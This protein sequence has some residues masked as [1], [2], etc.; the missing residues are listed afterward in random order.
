MKTKLH[1]TMQ[2]SFIKSFVLAAVTALTVLLSPT[3]VAQIVSSG[4]TGTVRGADGK[5]LAGATVTAVHTPTNATFST[6]ANDAGRFSFRSLPVGGPYTVSASSSGYKTGSASEIITQLGNDIEVPLTLESEVLQ[7]EKF[8]VSG[9]AADLN[10]NAT[11]AGTLLTADRL[12]TKPTAQ[13]SL[14]DLISAS[15]LVTLRATIGDR[16]ESQISAV[17]QNNRYNNVMIDGAKIN[18]QFGLNMTGLASFFNPLSIDTIEQL[19]VAVSPYDVRQSGFTGANINAVT[20]S[21]TNQFHGSLYYIWG[22][23]E[24]FGLQMQG[25][26]T[27]T[28]INTGA[29]NVPKL[30]RTTKGFTLGGPIWKNHVFFFLNYEKFER[31]SAPGAPGLLAVNNADMTAFIARLAKYNT[32]SGKTIPWG[33]NI[34]G[35][36]VTNITDDEKKLAKIDWQISQNH[37]ASVRY[38]TTEGQLPQYGNYQ[39]NT[40][41]NNVPTGVTALVSNGQTALS[42]HVYSQARLEKVWAGQFFSQWTPDF[43]TEVKYSQVKQDQYTPLQVVAPVLTVFNV[44]GTNSQGAATTTAA[45]TAGTEFSR[46][47][48]EIHTNSKNWSATGDYTWKNV[49]ISGGVEREETDFY[50]IFKNGSFGQV[51]FRTLQDFIDDKPARIDR[52]VY[53]PAKRPDPADI[54]D[55]ATNSIFAQAKW[56]VNSRLNLIAGVRY[57]IADMQAVPPYNAAFFAATGFRN[58]GTSDGVKTISPRVAFNYAL[59]EDRSIQLRGGLGHF[60]GRAPWVIFSNSWN[61]PGVGS[62]TNIQDNRTAGNQTATLAAGTFTQ[63]LKDFDVNNPVGTGTD[64]G[65]VR[66]VDWTD[67]NIRLPSVWR[68]NLAMDFQLKSLGAVATVEAVHTK[69]QDQL[70]IINENIKPSTIGADG[71]QRFTFSSSGGANNRFPGYANLYHTTNV[72]TGKSTYIAIAVDRPMK[73]NWS[74]NLSYTHGKATDAQ[75]F[76]QTTASG[77]WQRNVVFNQ[78][79]P[80][81]NTSDFEVRHRFQIT[82]SRQFEFFKNWKTT[83]SLYYEGRSGEPFS[84]VYTNDFNGDGFSGNDTVAV[85]SDVNDSRFSFSHMTSGQIDQYFA[86]LQTSG[87]SK[88]GGGYAP[89][90][91]FHT[92]WINRLDL[93]LSQNIPIW[94]IGEFKPKMEVFLDFINFGAFINED[95]F[96]GYYVEANQKHFGSEMF[97]RNRLGNAFY[98]ASGK[99]MPGRTSLTSAYTYGPDSNLIENGQSR[100]RIQVGARLK[101]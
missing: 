49:V 41:F 19:N 97:R 78:S 4:M 75:S 12:E 21:G 80:E 73:H 72:S 76:G 35:T 39:G 23:D 50:N 33:E 88:F 47:G 85:P 65:A 68:G 84:W 98:D 1:S 56:D 17:G 60:L 101:F 86:F 53:D 58:D 61:N 30:E 91:S 74:Y 42:T 31:I 3:A 66:Q 26:D 100:W 2:K 10:A 64:T 25:E 24:L 14:A 27:S 43:T 13:R 20:K 54:S 69:N 57:D 34:V 16:E 46:Q 44:G 82:L 99:I 94:G 83:A 87:L 77:Q 6:V 59:K 38:S 89:K 81:E 45:Y 51:V 32:D 8:S 90:N 67:D 37:R 9:S 15:P 5:A 29:K 95:I 62:F 71:R 70:F 7:L 63:Y 55:F 28:R 79:V 11:G 52:N 22:G 36:A 92:P 18:D 93:K 96:G 48:N 40:A